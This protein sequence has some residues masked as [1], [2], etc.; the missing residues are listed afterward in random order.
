LRSPRTSSCTR[1][2]E[3]NFNFHVQAP[4][5]FRYAESQQ[6]SDGAVT[7]KVE[8]TH[9]FDKSGTH[10][11]ALRVASQRKDAVGTSFAKAGNVSRVRVVVS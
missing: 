7:H 2:F 10:F 6:W 4:S 3:Q 9:R 1:A 5:N 8:R 11:V